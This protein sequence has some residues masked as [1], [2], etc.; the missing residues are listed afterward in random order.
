MRNP[1][2]RRR[3]MAAEAA[4]APADSGQPGRSLDD[5]IVLLRQ[6]AKD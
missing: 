3:R 5:C 4:A 6:L 1:D 2:K